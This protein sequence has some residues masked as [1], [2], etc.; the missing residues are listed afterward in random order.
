MTDKHGEE[1]GVQITEL[2]K[3]AAIELPAIAAKEADAG[4]VLVGSQDDSGVFGMAHGGFTQIYPAW[5]RLRDETLKILRTSVDNIYASA[6]ALVGIAE[7]YAASD[8]TA[9]RNFDRRRADEIAH[10]D[11]VKVPLYDD[12]VTHGNDNRTPR[13]EIKESAPRIDPD[14]LPSDPW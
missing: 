9:K 1:L 4:N 11:P 14:N 2:W 12:P 5:N 13:P 3:C 7:A 6:D 10:H 8:E